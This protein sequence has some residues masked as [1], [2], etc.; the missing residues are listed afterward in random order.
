LIGGI[1]MMKEIKKV[2]EN[3]FGDVEKFLIKEITHS[4]I[5]YGNIIKEG[6]ELKESNIFAGNCYFF[7]NTD[8]SQIYFVFSLC[9]N[10]NVLYVF[11]HQIE[12]NYSNLIVNYLKENEKEIKIQGFL[13]DYKNGKNF[14]EEMKWENPRFKEKSTL[15]KYE[16]NKN[17]EK[18]CCKNS[19]VLNEEDFENYFC[20]S[21]DF[22]KEMNLPEEEKQFQRIRYQSKINE[23][24]IFGTFEDDKLVSIAELNSIVKNYCIIGR[25]FTL[26][27]Y[28]KKGLSYQNVC[29]LIM[30]TFEN[31]KIDKFILFT[32]ENSNASKLYEKIGFEKIGD[33][34]LLIN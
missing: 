29:F 15:Y 3:N 7:C 25:V 17:I 8:E 30:N 2:D 4:L 1:I 33:H 5:L 14:E 21:N 6:Y 12:T 10:G 22:I 23:N 28:R 20:L 26:K 34:C 24:T 19:R 16:Y 18:I 11:D 9:K 32:E 31:K 13:G 27:D